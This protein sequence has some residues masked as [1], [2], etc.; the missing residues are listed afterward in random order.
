MVRLEGNTEAE[1]DLQAPAGSW[2]ELEQERNLSVQA[3][4]VSITHSLSLSF[5]IF[6]FLIC[7]QSPNEIGQANSLQRLKSLEP[8][9]H[10]YE[11]RVD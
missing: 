2:R 10:L 5:L 9:R 1:G 8:S 4:T 3:C 11:D 6:F 7:S